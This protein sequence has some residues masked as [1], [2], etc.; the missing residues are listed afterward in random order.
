LFGT[1]KINERFIAERTKRKTQDEFV[2][3]LNTKILVHTTT[4]AF[5]KD[6]EKKIYELKESVTKSDA[7]AIISVNI[8][9]LKTI[10]SK[11]LLC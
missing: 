2:L 5:F 6:A 11:F 10:R 7:A 1:T 9:F 8:P 3:I 4:R